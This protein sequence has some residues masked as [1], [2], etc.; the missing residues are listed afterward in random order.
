MLLLLPFSLLGRSPVQIASRFSFGSPQLRI[1]CNALCGV[2]LLAS[3]IAGA[4][5]AQEDSD[6]ERSGVA[7]S[8][9]H[10]ASGPDGNYQ[11]ANAKAP[12][13]WSV[14]RDEGVRWT[15]PL[16]EGGQSSP[17]VWGDRLFVTINEPWP[18][19]SS[20]PAVGANVIGYCLNSQTGN[21]LWTVDLP[22]KREM[23]YAGIF[24]DST[25]PSP[26]TDGEHVWFFNA[27]GMFGCWN[28]DGNEVWT[29]QWS[30]R[31]RHHSRQCEPILF[32]DTLLFV[33]VKNKEGA[34]I[35]MHKDY[36]PGTDL[37]QYWT[38]IH[39]YDKRT[40]EL[41]W[42][43]ST[44]TAIHN[45]P[46]IGKLR[47]GTLAVLHGRGGGHAPLEKPY[48]FS[49][50]VADGPRAGE[51]L[52]SYDIPKAAAY[53]TSAW[54]E[55]YCC[56]FHG[57]QHLVV[58]TNTGELLRSQTLDEGVTLR[59]FDRDRK[60]FG[61]EMNATLKI[62][63]RPGQT[64]VTNMANL[65][66]GSHHYFL[67]H[68]S[69]CIGR[70]NIE[71]G[72]VEYLEVPLNVVRPWGKPDE[73]IWDETL[74]ND[75]VNWR[76]VDIGLVDKRSK[77]SGWG[78]VSAAPP[79]AIGDRIYFTTMVGVTYV[80]DATADRLDEYAL[81]SINDLGP[82]GRTWS[83]TQPTFAN[84]CLYTRTMKEVLCIGPAE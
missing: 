37:K 42:T 9:W 15:T 84:G 7:T 52:W 48:G 79:I 27:S 50:T 57:N 14:S 22:G 77:G 16:P 12:T 51:T 30:P 49:L 18:K 80:I 45:T 21:I 64:P 10:Q 44:G 2:A 6:A 32:D 23:K 71:T 47:D 61:T 82:A 34:N 46:T 4:L 36:P 58:D 41:K 73:L 3:C 25:S 13:R 19:D 40:G 70:V 29:K 31:S 39:A 43:E 67:T 1:L 78:H 38:Y 63:R 20:K 83:L 11:I 69:H 76:G 8:H 35:G 55:K 17:V 28:L 54:N 74:I 24:S 75:T 81:L 56:W 65:L 59:C 68:E 62:S 5:R 53:F 26:V 33:E 72:D 60:E 66:V